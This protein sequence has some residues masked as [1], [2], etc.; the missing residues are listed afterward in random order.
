MAKRNE[1]DDV[2]TISQ[3]ATKIVAIIA[4]VIILWI[5][6][7]STID[8]KDIELILAGFVGGAQALSFYKKF[9]K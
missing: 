2:D 9:K 6:S 4:L 5:D 1:F 3:A 7:Q 8:A